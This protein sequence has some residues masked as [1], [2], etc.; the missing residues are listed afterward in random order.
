MKKANKKYDLDQCALYKCKSKKKLAELLLIDLRYI[1]NSKNF[2]N[3]H[4]FKLTGKNNKTRLINA[5]KPFLKKIQK[6]MLELL[7]PI[8]RPTWVMFGEKGKSYIQN[9]I[10]HQYNP[11]C[12]TM[13]I[14]GFYDHCRR[15]AV[16]RFCKDKLQ[17]SPDVATIITDFATWEQHIPTGSPVSQILAYHAYEDMFCKINEYAKSIGAKFTLYVDDITISSKNPIDP[18]KLASKVRRILHVYGHTI[19]KNKTKYYSKNDFKLITGVIIS[20][21]HQLLVPNKL[22]HKINNELEHLYSITQESTDVQGAIL[23]LNGLL[24]AARL[25]QP[26]YRSDI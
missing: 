6:R 23:R 26:N 5:P 16:Y 8:I 10:V 19:S 14:K 4:S 9:A 18:K 7:G 2:I 22:S 25:I 24:Q 13:D 3:Y 17:V 21:D 15:N 12:I 11:Y 20:P 1:K